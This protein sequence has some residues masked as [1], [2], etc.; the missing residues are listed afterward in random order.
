M[1]VTGMGMFQRRFFALYNYQAA[2][3]PR[4]FME[5]ER[6]GAPLGRLEFEVSPSSN[7]NFVAAV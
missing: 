3:N 7:A 6:N 5:V 1:S 4:V 2:S